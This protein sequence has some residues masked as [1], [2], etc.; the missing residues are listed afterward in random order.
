MT[1]VNPDD[2]NTA[3]QAAD[4]WDVLVKRWPVS[5]VGGFVGVLMHSK[6][7]FSYPGW[8]KRCSLIA[9]QWTTGAVAAMT[10]AILVGVAWPEATHQAEAEMGLG[11]FIGG[12]LGM[13]VFRFFA[14]RFFNVDL[15]V[16]IKPWDGVD[17]RG[18]NG[19][20]A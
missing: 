10:A 1:P 2:I 13:G 12:T 3:A 15:D 9:L 16:V 4:Y 14:K 6:E 7:I 11:G 19:N 5:V 18:K 17:R 8:R 20:G